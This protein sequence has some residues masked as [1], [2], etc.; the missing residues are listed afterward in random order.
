LS[1][2]TDIVNVL[3]G[4]KAQCDVAVRRSGGFSGPIELRLEELPEGVVLETP[5]IPAGAAT[6]KLTLAAGEK[7]A[8]G[9]SPLRLVGTA[10][11][12]EGKIDRVARCAHLGVDVTGVSVGPLSLDRLHLTVQ[13]KPVFRLFCAEAYQYAH[14]GTV[15]P[16]LMEVERLEGFD[17]PVTLQLGDRQN[18]DLDGIEMREIVI[19]PG[20]TQVMLPIYFPETMHINVQSQSQLYSQG[21]ATF[22]DQQGRSQSVLVVSEKRNILRTLPP[23]VKLKA[24]DKELSCRPGGECVC[25]FS[26]ERTKNF[27]GDMKLSLVSGSE[28]HKCAAASVVIPADH[29]SA[30]IRLN[31]SSAAPSGPRTV[32]FRAV[33]MFAGGAE[34]VTEDEVLLD[35]K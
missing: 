23:V 21:H 29:N 27:A 22:T 6:L 17:G 1:L 4:G 34:A 30:E 20:Q 26:L 13:H 31:V 35:V 11:L 19:P 5:Q 8:A 24:V 12:G 2:A 10:Q 33:G 7:A 32:R 18:R 14:R 16:Y 28:D 25:R 9:S 15:Y 3:P